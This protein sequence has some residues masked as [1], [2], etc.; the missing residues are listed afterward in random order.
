MVLKRALNEISKEAIEIVIDLIAQNSIYRG[1]EFSIQVSNFFDLK[2]KYEQNP[3]DLL[4]WRN[5]RTNFSRIKN[6]SIGE[7]LSDISEGV[8]SLDDCVKSYEAKVAPENYRRPSAVV[9]QSMVKNAK[10]FIEENGLSNSLF[11]RHANTSDVT[12]NNVLYASRGVFKDDDIFSN[13]MDNAVIKLPAMD[14]IEEISIEDFIKKCLPT[15][16]EVQ[17]Y[18]DDKHK[19]NLFSLIA[20]VYPDSKNILNWDN[21]FSWSYNGNV[22]DAIKERVKNA[23]GNVNGE[24]RISL[25]WFNTDDLD[26]SLIEPNGDVVYYGHRK[27][28]SGATLDVDANS[29][30]SKHTRTPVE[31]IYW[32][33][34]AGMVHGQYKV[35]VNQFH[36]RESTNVGFSLQVEL[37][38]VIKQFDYN[39]V[40][41]GRNVFLT[42]DYSRRDGI[43]F[44]KDIEKFNGGSFGGGG[45]SE[46]VWG[47][48]TKKFHRVNMALLSPNHWDGNEVGNKHY[49]FVL[50]GC[51]NKDT[52]RGLYNEFIKGT[53]EHRKVF[54]ALGNQLLVQPVDQQLSGLGF[55]STKKDAIIV[56]VTGSFER[57]LKV[58]I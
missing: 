42:F 28:I 5:I 49:L 29:P 41:M 12:V 34:I 17:V 37:N 31:N 10:K 57:L 33:K 25:S 24:F 8:L 43:T 50:D 4:I 20:P 30:F 48:N 11:R 35:V 27:G 21:N 19:A 51:A 15:A 54:E 53:N 39:R 3:S 52:C 18:F 13:L 45:G 36:K 6:T 44:G 47:I 9:S 38:G 56:K 58:I 7:L 16:K 2:T 22:T 55:S 23:G 32:D 40:V 46:E 14:K 26:I 1:K